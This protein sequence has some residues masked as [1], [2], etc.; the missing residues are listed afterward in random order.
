MRDPRVLEPAPAWRVFSCIVI[1]RV[2][3]RAP[4]ALLFWSGRFRRLR[5]LRLCCRGSRRDSFRRAHRAAGRCGWKGRRPGHQTSAGRNGAAGDGSDRARGSARPASDGLARSGSAALHAD[6]GADGGTRS[7]LFGRWRRPA[8]TLRLPRRLLFCRG[9]LCAHRLA[10]LDCAALV[11]AARPLPFLACLGGTLARTLGFAFGFFQALACPF[12]FLLGDTHTL[13][14]DF[15]QESCAA[16]GI[17]GSGFAA[18]LLH[19]R[20]CE[21]K[22]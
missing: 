19:V 20:A 16:G 21:G 6:P 1:S 9:A 17:S 15:R 10:G 8:G 14:G 5:R 3:G 12:Q 7:A 18:C 22:C 2:L 13:L 4:S 11:G